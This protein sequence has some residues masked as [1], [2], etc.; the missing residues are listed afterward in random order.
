MKRSIAPLVCCVYIS[1]M[2]DE[3]IDDA[4]MRVENGM[5]KA[6]KAANV[7]AIHV[8]MTR[9]VGTEGRGGGGGG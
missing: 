8:G 7:A 6:G 1:S 4:K 2:R 5:M 3:K 9:G